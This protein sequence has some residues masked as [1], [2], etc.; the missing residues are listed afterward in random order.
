MKSVY[1]YINE[2]HY[3]DTLI[4]EDACDV[5]YTITYK[6]SVSDKEYL[7]ARKTAQE[8]WNIQTA[9]KEYMRKLRERVD[10][11]KV[12]KRVLESLSELR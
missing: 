7:K 3:E 12:N 9:R 1:D 4:N 8:E 11:Q 5:D 2:N 10:Q 6:G